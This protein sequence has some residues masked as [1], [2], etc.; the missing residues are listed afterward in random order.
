MLSSG[1]ALKIKAACTSETSVKVYQTAR[2]HILKDSVLSIYNHV[3]YVLLVSATLL[4]SAVSNYKLRILGGPDS[5]ILMQHLVI[6]VSAVLRLKQTDRRTNRHDF[7]YMPSL[8]TVQGTRKNVI[9]QIRTCYYK[10]P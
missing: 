8:D 1:T 10:N 4:L 7:S 6:I 5:V 3:Y 2:C 9:T